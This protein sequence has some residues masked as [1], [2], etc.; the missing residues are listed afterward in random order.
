MAHHLDD[1][2]AVVA[3]GGAVQAIDRLGRNPERGVE[4]EAGVGHR[5]VVVDGLGQGDHRQALFDQPERVLLRPVAADADHRVQAVLPAVRHDHVAHVADAALDLHAVRLD[6]AGAENRAADREDAGQGVLVE[7]QRPILD[8]ARESRRGCRPPP[9][10]GRARLCRRRESPRSS[11]GQSP[12]AVRMPTR[13]MGLLRLNGG[14]FRALPAGRA[15]AGR[16]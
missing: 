14:T 7:R 15:P 11:P 6:A 5:H 12:P 3:V 1:D 13:L 16:Q 2:D 4:A 8:Q 9:C 10:R